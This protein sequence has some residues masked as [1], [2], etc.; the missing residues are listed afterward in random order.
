MYL[1][2]RYV[3][4]RNASNVDNCIGRCL[5]LLAEVDA[6]KKMGNLFAFK[7]TKRSPGDLVPVILFQPNL[8]Y[9]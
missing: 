8:E 2:H 6:E 9:C 7:G 3:L 4:N 5:K 1:T